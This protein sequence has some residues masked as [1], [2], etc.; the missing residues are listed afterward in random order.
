MENENVEFK[1]KVV[2]LGGSS[3]GAKTSLIYRIAFNSFNNSYQVIDYS[4]SN[5]YII[6]KNM[7]NYLGNIIQLDLWDTT[8][9]ERFWPLNKFFMKGSHCVILGYD[10]TNRDSFYGIENYWYNEVISVLGDL[11]LIYLVANK[12][13]LYDFEKVSEEEGITFAKNKNIKFFQVSAKTGDGVDDLLKDIVD[14]LTDKF[15]PKKEEKYIELKKN[16]KWIK[17]SFDKNKIKG[18][19]NKEKKIENNDNEKKISKKNLNNSLKDS[20][21]KFIKN[22]FKFLNF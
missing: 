19:N 7:K 22:I 3:I 1:F 17:N 6:C 20:D 21:K 2:F 8:G 10:I 15:L 9:Q 14:S 4:N 18:N 12:I 13:D 11:P 16:T 5:S